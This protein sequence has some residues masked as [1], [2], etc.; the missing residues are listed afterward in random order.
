MKTH[1]FSAGPG[2]LPQPVLQEIQANFLDFDNS[3]IS[4]LETSHRSKQFSRVIEECSKD[5]RDLMDIPDEFAVLYIQ[6]GGSMQFGMWLQN[7]KPE[8]VGECTFNT[9][10]TSYNY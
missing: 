9:L 2:I 8:R 1:N 4:I 10:P 3:G 6:G 7:L 5:L